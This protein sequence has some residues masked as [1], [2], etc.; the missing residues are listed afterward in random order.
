[1][2]TQQVKGVNGVNARDN[3][4]CDRKLT[5]NNTHFNARCKLGNR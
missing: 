1:M 4:L 5:A 2:W 3:G